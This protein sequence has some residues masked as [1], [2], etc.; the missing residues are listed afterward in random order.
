MRMW[1]EVIE[2]TKEKSG[3][4]IIRADGFG[5]SGETVDQLP[6]SA[7]GPAIKGGSATG[8]SGFCRS[9]GAK[10]LLRA[11]QRGTKGGDLL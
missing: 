4:V 7:A 6:L 9:R 5:Q 2:K 8:E 11:R 3:Y 10:S 1:A